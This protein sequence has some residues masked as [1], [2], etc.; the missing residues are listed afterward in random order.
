MSHEWLEI[1]P[2]SCP[3]LG[4]LINGDGG[5]QTVGI[6]AAPST[7]LVEKCGGS[8]SIAPVQRE[9]PGFYHPSTAVQVFLQ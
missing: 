9:N 6:R 8:L 4:I 1:H 3:Q 2:V 5:D 7:G